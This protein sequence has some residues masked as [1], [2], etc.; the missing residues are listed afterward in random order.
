MDLTDAAAR[1]RHHHRQAAQ[2]DGETLAVRRGDDVRWTEGHHHAVSDV[3]D[4]V[5]A[6]GRRGFPDARRTDLHSRR[7][8]RGNAAAGEFPAAAACAES[9]QGHVDGNDGDHHRSAAADGRRAVGP[10]HA[11]QPSGGAYGH[12]FLYETHH[13]V[14]T[15]HRRNRSAGVYAAADRRAQLGEG[16]RQEPSGGRARGDQGESRREPRRE[17]SGGRGL[18][19]PARPDHE[20][21]APHRNRTQFRPYDLARQRPVQGAAAAHGHVGETREQPHPAHDP[22]VQRRRTVRAYARGPSG[23]DRTCDRPAV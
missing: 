5:H 18:R 9:R 22:A 7:R 20:L 13:A 12:R 6:G 19:A 3:H 16:V 15:A 14:E 4:S 1:A 2:D 8:D 11:R 17:R 23:C 21:A 10:C